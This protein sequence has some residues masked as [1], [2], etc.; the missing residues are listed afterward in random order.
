MASENA[1]DPAA[2]VHYINK[3]LEFYQALKQKNHYLAMISHSHEIASH[4]AAMAIKK[5]SPELRWL[6]SF[7]DPIAANPFNDS[8]QFPM[9]KEDSQTEAQ[10]LQQ[11]DRIIVT[12]R[13]Q[14]DL[15]V[16]TQTQQLDE[17]KYFVLPHCFDERMYPDSY[18]QKSNENRLD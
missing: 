2:R 17:E 10:V 11:A 6:A 1:R 13:Y 15:V 9:L 14:Q 12:N 5:R 16:A 18:D 3:V 8:Y 7:G 4:M